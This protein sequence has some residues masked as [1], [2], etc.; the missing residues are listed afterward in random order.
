[1]PPVLGIVRV[2]KDTVAETVRGANLDAI[3]GAAGW[4]GAGLL[5]LVL[6]WL[7][8][9]Y[10]PAKDQQI[11]IIMKNK[12]AQVRDLITEKDKQID[13]IMRN[14]DTQVRDLITEKDKQLHEVL[15]SKDKQLAAKDQQ[16]SLL[17]DHE[18]K[19]VEKLSEDHRD[20]LKHISSEF[21]DVTMELSRHCEEEIQR[22]FNLH[23]KLTTTRE[24]TVR[25]VT[26]ANQPEE[27]K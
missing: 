7:C 23:D 17:L 1:M 9:K 11:D 8:F 21:K 26:P 15:S 6:W 4:T 24:F 20:A 13:T 19:A 5:G 16:M 14:K 22:M 12:D 10:L 27:K 25:D 3:T 18:W 2:I